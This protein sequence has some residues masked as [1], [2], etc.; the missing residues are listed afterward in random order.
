[1]NMQE[2]TT[3]GTDSS[4]TENASGSST[5]E[6]STMQTN[7]DTTVSL[8]TRVPAQTY[9]DYGSADD[10]IAMSV[11]YCDQQKR[12]KLYRSNATHLTWI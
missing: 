5:T 2:S 1:M 8:T 4:T 9:N 3:V 11:K 7:S 10:D 12:N 6:S